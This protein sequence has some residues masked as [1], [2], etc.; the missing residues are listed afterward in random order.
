MNKEQSIGKEEIIESYKVVKTVDIIFSINHPSKI[1]QFINSV[2]S[3]FK[4][5][6][7]VTDNRYIMKVSKNRRGN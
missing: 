7:G 5:L 1:K 3:F 4:L 6:F 2:V